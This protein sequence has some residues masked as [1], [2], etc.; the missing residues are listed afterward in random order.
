M[1]TTS[2]HCV[3]KG[4]LKESSGSGTFDFRKQKFQ[5]RQEDYK[6]N[7]VTYQP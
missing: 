7:T 3:G 1:T 6:I 5:A 4:M 2:R